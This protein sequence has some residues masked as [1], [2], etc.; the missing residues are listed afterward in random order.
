MPLDPQA[1]AFLDQVVAM[2]LPPLNTLSVEEARQATAALSE[3]HGAPEPVAS[4][5]NLVAAG[6]AGEIPLRVYT[7]EQ[8]GP[9]PLLIYLH[10]G[11]WV[12]GDLETHDALCRTLT[13]SVG[14]MV[15][16]VDY[17]LA[18]EHKFPAAA[19]DAYA[20]TAWVAAHA[21]EIGGD[22]QRVAVGGDSAGGNLAAVAALMARDRG[23]PALVHQLLVY[24]VTDSAC[25]TVSCR[26][27]AEGYFLTLDMMRWF[28]QHYLRSASDGENPYA[29]P[30]RARDLRGL[31]AA[32]VIT[33]E[34]DPLRDEGEAY[35]ARLR[36]AGVRVQLKRYDG[37]I[38]GFF[39][40]SA[41][42]DRAR[43]AIQDA[44]AALQDAFA[45]PSAAPKIN[46]LKRFIHSIRSPREPKG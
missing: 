22:P 6:P 36:A 12:I 43:D 18:P 25:D 13:N 19:E 34:F 5:D 7:P 17:R 26:E 37:M 39:G 9:Y 45:A 28:W 20:A 42:L 41:L 46:P 27:N 15:A 2:N 23:G 16:S 38:H 21:A 11:G 29:A 3:M 30:L 44:A 32:L 8:E 1:Q 10:G 14:C 35:A 24:P 33:A 31:P 4:V 40:M